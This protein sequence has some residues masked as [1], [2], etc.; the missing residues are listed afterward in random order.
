[1]TDATAGGF[2]AQVVVFGLLS[3][4]QRLQVAAISSGLHKLDP[5]P[6]ERMIGR[7][8][9]G[10]ADRLRNLAESYAPEA[11]EAAKAE[12]EKGNLEAAENLELQ[13]K[14]MLHLAHLLSLMLPAWEQEGAE[15][16]G[17]LMRFMFE[18]QMKWQEEERPQRHP[19][20][21]TS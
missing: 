6:C 7:Q 4:L 19:E 3:L 21:P 16:S 18:S 17:K 12:R 15:Q 1:M 13:A 8:A 10:Y 2:D 14:S 9:I 20:E 5:D 11:M